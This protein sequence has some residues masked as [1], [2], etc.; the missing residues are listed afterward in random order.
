MSLS[1][2]IVGK[3]PPAGWHPISVSPPLDA[4]LWVYCP[5]F[6]YMRVGQTSADMLRYCSDATHWH[7]VIDGTLIPEPPKKGLTR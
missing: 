5:S 4:R 6:S 1:D 3:R 2:T 7:L